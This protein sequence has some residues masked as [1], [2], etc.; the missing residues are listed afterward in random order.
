M[1]KKITR[2]AWEGLNA[3]VQDCAPPLRVT[4]NTYV[5]LLKLV[6]YT[7]F[8]EKHVTWISR[9]WKHLFCSVKLLNNPFICWNIINSVNI[10]ATD[11]RDL[12][13]IEMFFCL[14]LITSKVCYKFIK[15][16]RTRDEVCQKLKK[17]CEPLT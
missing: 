16:I 5:N 17:C 2:L 15:C 10:A 12:K 1:W 14:F 8:T 11:Q 7:G 6:L 13:I 4:A 9:I 3:W